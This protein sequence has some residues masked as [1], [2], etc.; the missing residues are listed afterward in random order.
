MPVVRLRAPLSELAGG[1]RELELEGS[2]VAEVLQGARA[3]APR[4]ARLDPRRARGDPGAHQRL[5]EQG[6]RTGGHGGRAERPP[7]RHSRDLRRVRVTE[8]LVGTK[9]GLFVL[10]GEP[11]AA[12]E[13]TS[14]HFAGEPVEFATRDARS[15]QDVRLR[16]LGVLRAEDLLHG[17]PRRRVAAGERRRAPRGRREAARAPLDGRARRGRRP[18]LRGR[19]AGHPLREPRRRRELGA[20]QGVL[21]AADAARLEPRR[22]RHVHALDRDLAG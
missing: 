12:F 4:H 13:V 3:R 19:R 17:R 22:G 18:P 16:D 6:V 10:E 15:G 2:T 8:L 20:E 14:R 21:G 1:K 9:K 7:P 5:R 11:A